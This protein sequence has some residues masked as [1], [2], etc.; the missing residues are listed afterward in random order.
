M[1]GY[2]NFNQVLTLKSA[3]KKDGRLLTPTD[4][5]IIKN[6]AI[7]YDKDK[8]IWVGSSD[9]IPENLI[10][11]VEWKDASGHVL[12]PEVVDS[13]THLV[14]GGNRA[15]EY[16]MRLNGADYEEIGKAGGGILSTMRSTNKASLDELF[17][18]AVSRVEKIASYGVG[19]IEIKSGY[20]LNY[21]KEKEITFLIDRL[22]KHFGPSIKIINTFMPAHAVPHDFDSSHSYLHKVCLPLLK[23]LGPLK[24]IDFVDIFHELNYFDEQDVRDLASVAKDFNIKLK[25]HSDEFQDNEGAKLACE[26]G[27]ASCDHLLETSKDGIKALSKSPTVATLLPGT[28]FFLGKKQANAREFLDSGVKVA[29][30]SD[31]NPGSCHC[32]NLLF[33]SSLAAPSLKLNIAEL[34]ASITL[35]SAHSLGLTNQGA[36]IEG[37]SPR[38][39]FFKVDTIDEITYNWG[40][41]YAVKAI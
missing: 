17:D 41:N 19:T 20:S 31:Y 40:Q 27:A 8:I 15:S 36:I 12:T 13:H 23:E 14:F 16:S 30:A 1:I 5:S 39:S 10:N 6:G 11:K 9:N 32:D 34:W 38:F 2:K 28:G 25:I 37:L 22:K 29:L 4:L 3:H 26:L 7:A 18:K 21:D 24:I 33:I 35:N